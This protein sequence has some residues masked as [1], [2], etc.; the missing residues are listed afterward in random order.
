M[1]DYAKKQTDHARNFIQARRAIEEARSNFD[2]AGPLAQ[3]FVL[4]VV[5][6]RI[7]GSIRL[8]RTTR[9][10][11]GNPKAQELLAGIPPR[12]GWEQHYKM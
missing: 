2:I 7:G 5:A 12:K 4:G 3:T 8:P 10:V 9:K 11:V 1:P 6:Q